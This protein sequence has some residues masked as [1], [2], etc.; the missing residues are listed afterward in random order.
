MFTGII[1][2]IGVVKSFSGQELIVEA[3]APE[4]NDPWQIGE[5]IAING[6]CLTVVSASSDLKFELSEETIKRT[7]FDRIRGGSSVNIE[8]AMKANGRFGGHIVQGHVDAVGKLT[9]VEITPQAHLMRFSVPEECS[10]YLMDKGSI[11][12]SG[13]SLTVVNPKQNEFE[14][15]II[16]HTWEHTNLSRLVEGDTVNL[17]FDVLAKYI[18]RLLAHK[19]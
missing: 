11:T 10:Q 3:P 6:C 12:V 17:E 5:S 7:A 1:E 14:V 8:R 18:E 19:Q 15:W 16:P 9:T 4:A 2:S 13:I